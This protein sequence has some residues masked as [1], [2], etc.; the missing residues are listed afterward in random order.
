MSWYNESKKIKSSY[1]LNNFFMGIIFWILISFYL[2]CGTWVKNLWEQIYC[3]RERHMIELY[4][5]PHK[6]TVYIYIYIYIL[7]YW[8]LIDIDDELEIFSK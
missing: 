4:A 7:I 1:I 6:V 5:L 8:W 3:Q 2:C